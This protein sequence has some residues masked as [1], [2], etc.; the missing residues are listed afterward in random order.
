MEQ[1]SKSELTS[2]GARPRTMTVSGGGSPSSR[3]DG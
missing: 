3:R 2:D 1:V